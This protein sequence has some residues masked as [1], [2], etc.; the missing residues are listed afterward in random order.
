MARLIISIIYFYRWVISP[1]LPP[2]CRFEPTCSRYAIHAIECH[3]ITKGLWMT[4]KRLARCHPYEQFSKQIG[5]AWGY[6]PVE[7]HLPANK[8]LNSA[9]N[10]S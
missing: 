8:S 7:K 4:I 2:R 1:F 9:K 3:G 5:Q 10:I 6:D